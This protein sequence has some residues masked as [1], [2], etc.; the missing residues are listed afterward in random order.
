MLNGLLAGDGHL[1]HSD[2]TAPQG[3]LVVILIIYFLQGLEGLNRI[4]EMPHFVAVV[5]DKLKHIEGIGG[6]L[7]R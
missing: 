4:V 1:E 2:H 3:V 5:A 7:G 6:G